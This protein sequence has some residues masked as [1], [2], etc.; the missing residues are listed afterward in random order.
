MTETIL[1]EKD[2]PHRIEKVWRA[3]TEGHLL[4]DWL[5]ENDF[6]PIVG[7]RFTFRMKPMPHWNGVTDC[8]VTEVTP[9]TRLAYSW[10]SSGDEAANGVRTVV[11]WTLAPTPAGVRLRMEQSGFR[12]DQG[13]AQGGASIGW[14]QFFA[15][16]DDVL[17]RE[18][19]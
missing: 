1:I 10:S 16:L 12:P 14:R 17:A 8:E 13:R 9:M 6:R 11:T 19:G 2:L 5:M 3:L 4:A 15:R 7:H 18:P